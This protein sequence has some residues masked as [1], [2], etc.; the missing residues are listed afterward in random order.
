V[1]I[2]VGLPDEVIEKRKEKK[3]KKRKKRKER[4]KKI[5]TKHRLVG[6]EYSKCTRED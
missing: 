4:E 6:R 3:K 1:H 5:K 2:E